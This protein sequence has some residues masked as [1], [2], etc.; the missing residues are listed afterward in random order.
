MNNKN[1]VIRVVSSVVD[2]HYVGLEFYPLW[3][4]PSTQPLVQLE[5]EPVDVSVIRHRRVKGGIEIRHLR[6]RRQHFPGG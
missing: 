2:N 3:K 5:G 1:S 4:S 6:R